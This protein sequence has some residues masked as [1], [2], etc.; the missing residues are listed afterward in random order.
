MERRL[1]IIRRR[2]S[3]RSG[4]VTLYLVATAVVVALIGLGAWLFLG[5]RG[6]SE[7]DQPLTAKVV[8]A[9]FEH[10]IVEQGEVESSI[11]VE[12]KSHVK[13]RNTS[14]MQILTVIPDG[15]I[16]EEGQEVVQL[17]ASALEQ[18]RDT[19]KIACNTSL[20]LKVQAENTYQAAVIARTEYLEGTFQQEKQTI[21]SEIFVAEENLRRAENY[22][23]YSQ[24]LAGK[25]F[26]T[27][28]QLEADRFAVEKAKS[29][30]SLAKRKLFVLENYTREKTTRTLDSDIATAK[31]KWEAEEESY[32]L[33]LKK[34][35]DVEEQIAN[36]TITAPQAGR[37]VYANVP[38]SRGGS[39]EF[40]VEAGTS[41]REGQVI[42]RMPDTKNMQV[43]A[44]INESRIRNVKE[45]QQ[46]T[47]K[48]DALGNTPL[49][50][51]VKKVNRFAE[52]SSWFSSAVKQYATEITILDPPDTIMTGLTAEVNIHIERLPAAIQV[53]VQSVV[54]H[55][56]KAYVLAQ[57]GNTWEPQPVVIGSTNDSFVRIESGLSADQLVAANPRQHLDRFPFVKD[58]QLEESP[59]S[60]LTP[61]EQVAANAPPAGG[62]PGVTPAGPVGEGDPNKKRRNSN[63]AE[64][65]ARMDSDGD[66]KLSSTEWDAIPAGFRDS[67]GNAD[68]NGDG[69][70]DQAELAAAF[71]RMRTAR[72]NG[73]AGE[74]GLPMPPNRAAE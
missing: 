63:P 20:A 39:A 70:V 44:K 13:S 65:F 32:K 3:R 15:S 8:N 46:V 33:E 14:G 59:T 74:G 23:K 35:A 42:L 50:G 53:P 6:Q 10:S 40:I 27:S 29:D 41:V 1:S 47:I 9:A 61:Q 25:G 58:G 51:V 64:A 36:C 31:A 73:P 21:Q 34:L 72:G 49:R 26:V 55:Q 52:P 62:Q 24:R 7:Q 2:H 68:A 43:R 22:A 37:V 67:L 69:H 56:G 45:G 12:I 60:I 57:K 16:V 71:A 18:E 66:G 19:Q 54:E 11:N 4:R 5:G 28:Q 38:N 30:L 48:I 17:D